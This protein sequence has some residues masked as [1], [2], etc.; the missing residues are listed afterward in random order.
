MC[1]GG[2]A[3]GTVLF[4]DKVYDAM[5][6]DVKEVF[7]RTDINSLSDYFATPATC[8]HRGHTHEEILCG[9]GIWTSM[10]MNCFDIYKC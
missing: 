4:F 5:I 3:G 9:D 1:L 2:V 10:Y 7:G 8:V 6:Y